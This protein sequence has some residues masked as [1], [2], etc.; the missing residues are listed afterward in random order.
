MMEIK[1]T[2]GEKYVTKHRDG[3]N[4]M[5]FLERPGCQDT[6]AKSKIDNF[7]ND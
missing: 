1:P 3:S 5:A 4:L 7:T 6:D 2:V